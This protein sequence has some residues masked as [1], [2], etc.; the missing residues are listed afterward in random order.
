MSTIG[1]A[2][3]QKVVESMSRI[4]GRPVM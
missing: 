3:T 2:F 1:G 4:D